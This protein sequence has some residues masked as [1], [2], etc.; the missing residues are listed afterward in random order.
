MTNNLQAWLYDY[1]TNRSYSSG[2][3]KW[4]FLGEAFAKDFIKDGWPE[5]EFEEDFEK[6]LAMIVAWLVECRCYPS[7]PHKIERK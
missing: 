4:E 2:F 3:V 7:L 6:A 1:N 5:L